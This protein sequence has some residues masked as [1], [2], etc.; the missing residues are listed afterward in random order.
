MASRNGRVTFQTESTRAQMT[1]NGIPMSVHNPTDTSTMP[2][3][4]IVSNQ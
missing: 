4:R 3:V 1:P 2:M